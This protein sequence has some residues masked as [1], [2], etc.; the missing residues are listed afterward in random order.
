MTFQAAGV[1]GTTADKLW[2]NPSIQIAIQVMEQL[3]DIGS[4]LPFVAPAFVLLSL[5]IQIEKQA[6]D[7]DAKCNDLV[8]RITFMLGHLTVLRRVKMMDPTRL[9]VDRMIT[10][11]RD[12]AS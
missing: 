1:A 3:S 6:C 11:L 12:A 9:V 5:I 4:A 7:A 8:D 10:A 2:I